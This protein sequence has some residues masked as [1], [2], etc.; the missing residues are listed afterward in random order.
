M[1][2]NYN[3]PVNLI[4]GRG[5]A[6][7]IGHIAA[8]WG[9]KALLVTGTGSTKKS[10]LLDRTISC[11]KKAEVESVIFDRV[12]QNPLTTTAM[13]GTALSREASCDMVVGLG[14][15]SIMDC[16]KAIA[17]LHVN[18]G[19]INEY[20]FNKRISDKALP[21]LLIP[22][23]CGT[24]SEGN[25]FAVL[26]NP[27]TGD[28]KSLRSNAVIAK[29][30]IIDSQL[31]ETLPLPVLASVGF[32]ALCHSMEAWLSKIGQPL[33]DMMSLSAIELLGRH[34]PE[35][36]SGSK[37]PAAWDAVCWASTLGGMA[38]NSAGITLPHAMEHPASGLKNII[39]GRGLAALTPVITEKSC[40]ASPQ[41]YGVISRLLGG[42]DANDCAKRLRM[43]LSDIGLETT[44]SAQGITSADIPWMTENCFHVSAAGIANHPVSF[45][46]NEISG[47]YQDAL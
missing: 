4:F 2:F 6:E 40:H 21:L 32:D 31:M 27:E 15:G 37:D 39:H 16:A 34:L 26:T 41:K 33:T 25:G 35:L 19:D 10:G 8:A 23:T 12:T 5:R 44:L 11:L 17:F 24:G 30:S 3:L 9:H 14:G 47:L 7:E 28:K 18:E 45:T 43:L 42:T 29:A 46:K 20:I 13:E 22:T 36:C 1:N 38:I